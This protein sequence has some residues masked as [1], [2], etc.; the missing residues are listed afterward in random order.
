MEP[1][2]DEK[3]PANVKVKA[4]GAA[5]LKP[6]EVAMEQIAGKKR[7]R[8]WVYAVEPSAAASEANAKSGEMEV[9]SANGHGAGMDGEA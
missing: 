1:S 8:F 2:I 5:A 4:T 3:I 7:S 9:D 6:N